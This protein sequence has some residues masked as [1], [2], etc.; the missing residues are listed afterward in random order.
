MEFTQQRHGFIPEDVKKK[1][2]IV[3]ISGNHR[4]DFLTVRY[5]NFDP[6]KSMNT[7]KKDET[8]KLR[9]AELLREIMDKNEIKRS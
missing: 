5:T 8:W 9:I 6:I 4:P 3:L 7:A 2:V 1:Q